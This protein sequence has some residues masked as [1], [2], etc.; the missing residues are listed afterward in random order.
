VHLVSVV[1][2]SDSSRDGIIGSVTERLWGQALARTRKAAFGR[3]ATLFGATELDHAFWEDLEAALILADMGM[4]AV[5]ALT[6]DLRVQAKAQGITTRNEL[7]QALQALLAS[8]LTTRSL[9]LSSPPSVIMLIGVNGSGK[10]TTAARLGKRLQETGRRVLFAAADTYRAAASEQLNIWGERLGIE[11]ERGPS[12]SDAGAI[13]HQACERALKNRVDVLLVDT[14][15]RMH[16]EH[17]LMEELKKLVRVAGK[18]IPGAP[19]EM[20]L[21]LDA[22]TGQNGLQQA[23]SFAQ[24][25]PLSGVILAK[26]DSSAKGGVGFAVQSNLDLPILFVGLGEGAHDL[27]PFEPHAFALG[28][29]EP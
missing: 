1:I 11:V 16:T 25:V 23:R 17:N 22:T 7:L 28:L 18:V 2:A 12:G 4:D 26:L 3:V 20:L 19:H 21:V 10:T 15:G 13:V 24:E 8:R 5:L 27:A 6:D 29:L 14:S 9:N